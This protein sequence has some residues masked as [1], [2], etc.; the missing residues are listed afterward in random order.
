VSGLPWTRR[1]LL[2]AGAALAAT[3]APG[4]RVSAQD[5]RRLRAADN[6]DDDF[7][8]VQA[9]LYM[10]RY[11]RERSGNRLSIQVFPGGQLGEEDET[12][13]QT[14]IGAIDLTRVNLAPMGRFIPACNAFCLPFLIRSDEHLRRVIDGDVGE[15]ILRSFEQRGLVG[16]AFYEAGARSIY[17]SIRPVRTPADLRGLRIRVQRSDFMTDLMRALGTT[18]VA[19][20]YSQLLPALQARLIDGA[21]NN[22]PSYVTTDHHRAARFYTLTEHA[23]PPEVLL[24]SRKSWDALAPAD[25]ELIRDAALASRSFARMRMQEWTEIARLQAAAEGAEIIQDFDREAFAQA[26]QPF[27]ERAMADPELERMAGRIRQLA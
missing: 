20:S 1:R 24:I 19:L 3:A 6:Q 2:G 26:L 10:D 17:N 15:E 23:R 5:R 9:L 8:T 13:E 18:P 7:P 12:I 25:R 21:E 16:L 27:A 14:R 22:W 4:V 11:M